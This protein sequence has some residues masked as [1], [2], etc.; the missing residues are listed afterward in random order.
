MVQKRKTTPYQHWFKLSWIINGALLT[1][2][3]VNLQ[4]LQMAWLLMQMGNCGWHCM[5]AGLSC[6]LTQKLRLSWWQLKCQ[7][8]ALQVWY[9]QV[10]LSLI[11]HIHIKVIIQWQLINF[12]FP[13]SWNKKCNTVGA[14]VKYMGAP[15]GRLVLQISFIDDS[16]V[17]H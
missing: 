14:S 9:L 7:F 4:V 3:E 13:N 12:L 1:N 15:F 8:Y 11:N 10:S 17:L 16:T 5:G 6:K 2:R